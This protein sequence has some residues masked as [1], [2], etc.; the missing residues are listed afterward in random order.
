L[1]VSAVT[2]TEH[3]KDSVRVPLLTMGGLVLMCENDQLESCRLRCW[4]A[5]KPE[6][7]LVE[8]TGTRIEGQVVDRP[9][10]RGAQLVVASTGE[11]LT[12]FTVSDSPEKK[13]LALIGGYKIQEGY[14]GPMQ[15]ALGPD[16]Q[17]WLASSAFRKFQVLNDSIRLDQNSTAPGIA[18]QPLQI[19]GDQFFVAR[20]PPYAEGVIVT[21]VD[22]ERMAG[23][24]RA[25]LG[26]RLL[27]WTEA[28]GG[29]LI[30]VS[31]TGTV[32]T[33]TTSRLKQ[34]GVELRSG[35][36]LEIPE[37]VTE[38]L[39]AVRLSD[40]RLAL[41][42]G[43]PQAKLWIINTVGQ[44]ESEHKLDASLNAPPVLLKGGLALPQTGRLKWL[45]LSREGP[46]VQ[47]F[48]APFVDGET[49]RWTFL[50]GLDDKE[51][52]ACDVNGRLS[53]MQIRQDDVVHLAEAAMFALPQRVD[54][55]P[56]L[57]GT[58]LWIADVTG[59]L[60]RLD[61][62]SFDVKGERRFNRPVIGLWADGNDR[63]AQ[64]AGGA[65][66]CVT[67]AEGMPDRW[68]ADLS[69]VDLLDAP[70]RSG[71]H[72]VWVGRDGTV[73]RIDGET[74]AVGGRARLPQ[75]LSLGLTSVGGSLFASAADGAIYR[76][77]APGES[78]P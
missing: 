6:E 77:A 63:F 78:Q 64:L 34:G 23:S 5:T 17:F 22:R 4:D 3:P 24:W 20:R 38:P 9:V 65:L 29:G 68:T 52:V 33:L 69:G 2:F 11:R 74:G 45:S 12:A 46:R 62:R 55:P 16:Q 58:D 1:E 36:E 32:F 56:V 60:R 59:T 25:V 57:V 39:D 19:I 50:T 54:V 66:H 21:Q 51:F 73:L 61:S 42:C 8:A 15:L 48:M 47:D 49:V 72:L 41:W 28:R 27:A 71:D 67:D 35:L 30:A 70:V 37:G 75:S 31:E 13:G 14:A 43:G 76:V 40:G 26:A 18:S 10:L 44:V 7:P 53:R